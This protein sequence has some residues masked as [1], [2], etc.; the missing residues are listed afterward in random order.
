MIGGSGHS[1]YKRRHRPF[2]NSQTTSHRG[3]STRI[4]QPPYPYLLNPTNILP[5]LGGPGGLMLASLCQRKNL[6]YT[7]LEADD[8]G[9]A[10]TQGGS[11]DIHANSGQLALKEAGLLDAFMCKSRIEREAIKLLSLEG[12][13]LFDSAGIDRGKPEIDRTK[14]RDMLLGSL[15]PTHIKWGCK[16]FY[17]GICGLDIWTHDVDNRKPHLAAL[18][19]QG[20]CFSFGDGHAL[21]GQ[22]SGD[23]TIR[24][25][26]IRAAKEELARTLFCKL[27]DVPK[28][29]LLDTDDDATLRQL[30]ML[31]I[32]FQWYS[33]PGGTLLGDAAHLMTPFVGVG[34]N[35]ALTDALELAQALESVAVRAQSRNDPNQV[36]CDME[37]LADALQDYEKKMFVRAKEAATATY[38]SLQVLFAENAEEQMVGIMKT[39]GAEE[40]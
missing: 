14:L 40:G 11:L 17:S 26:D 31:P 10:R 20:A 15:D 22:R 27:G 9:H 30:Y 1:G 28:A 35:V 4:S 39:M 6:P 2:M 33:R 24:V 3:S 5:I 38:G 19:G 13:V 16:P 7:V 23:G 12:N 37:T 25:S 18:I 8:S 36:C 29:M 21:L 32:G 34:V